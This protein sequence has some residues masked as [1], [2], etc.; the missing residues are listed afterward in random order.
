VTRG[1]GVVPATS[2]TVEEKKVKVRTIFR[3][4]V[5]G[6]AL[7]LSLGAQAVTI[8]VQVTGT[9]YDSY[10]YLGN[11]FGS[12]VAGSNA[13]GQAVVATFTYNTALAPADYNG[14]ASPNY[15]NY[16]QNFYYGAGT[17]FMQ[18]SWTVN[19]NTHATGPSSYAD[20]YDIEQ[21]YLANDVGYDYVSLY[22]YNY[23]YETRGWKYAYNT[24]TWYDYTQN[25]VNGVAVDTLVND[26]TTPQYGYGHF[27]FYDYDNASG[28]SSYAYGSY[29]IN[30]VTASI[31]DPQQQQVPE[32]ATLALLGIAVAAFGVRRRKRS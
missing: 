14:G 32:P 8:E 29:T 3:S 6:A 17:E 27:N 21:V 18:S 15:A 31:L 19:G 26:A 23:D 13:N 1:T 10:D 24:A 12:G 4:V 30:S 16:V 20:Y 22:D 11:A 7:A 25:L 28:Y 5:A 2:S 9:I